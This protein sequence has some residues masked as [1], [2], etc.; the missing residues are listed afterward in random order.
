M[1]YKSYK[2]SEENNKVIIENVRDF[3]AVHV[4]ECGQ[5]FRWIRQEDGS[6]TGV[7][8]DRVVNIRYADGTLEIL[9]STAQDFKDI[10]FDYLDLGR[11][12][13]E[14]K[15]KLAEK[16]EIL[17]RAIEF[18]YGI[19]LLRQD[20]WETLISFIISANNRIP[21]IM[22]TVGVLSRVYGKEIEFEGQSYY[23]FPSVDRL[24]N[25]TIDDLDVCKGGF[26]CKYIY[27]TAN[28]VRDG[29]V[30]L[31]KLNDVGTVSAREEL[32]KFPGV[33]PK[34]ADCVLLFSGTKQ[35]VFP[36]D[37]WVKRVME[38]LYF[39]R[40]ASF[41]EIQ[42]FVQ[43]YFGELAGIA[44]QYLFYYARENRIGAT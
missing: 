24:A 12:Y 17:R 35:D 7:A 41:K 13:G 22:K 14:I 25:T 3:N 21:R 19:R 26:R 43:D 28:M 42:E 34:V 5:S 39:K 1:E 37:V 15:D 29:K 20:I 6:Y 16:D 33:G 30:D 23:S 32:M 2:V 38:E 9:N 40:E 11:D 27:H 8:K 44:Q 31:R 4:F 36:T 10:W 18:G